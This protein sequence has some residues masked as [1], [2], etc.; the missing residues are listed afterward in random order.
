M[1]TV[2]S[3]RQDPMAKHRLIFYSVRKKIY[4]KA[5]KRVYLSMYIIT[6]VSKR[7]AAALHSD[8]TDIN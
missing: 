6:R 3:N 8:D 4:A 2:F 5:F 7:Y 1:F